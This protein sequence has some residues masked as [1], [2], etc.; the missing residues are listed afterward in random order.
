PCVG[1]PL[2]RFNAAGLPDL[3]IEL[4]EDFAQRPL[5]EQHRLVRGMDGVL[6][7]LGTTVDAAFLDAAGPSLKV[8]SNYAVGYDNIDLQ[9]AAS[10]NVVVCNGPPPMTEPTADLAWM[11]LI[12]A[13]RRAREGL[14]LAL[15][16]NWE[17]YH[18]HL[19][20]GRRLVG[21]TLLVV[22]AGRIGSAIARRSLGWDMEVLYVARSDKPELEDAPL[23]ARRVTL[24][25]GLPLAD[26]VM[27]SVGLTP[28]TRG[29]IGA[30]ELASMKST[31]VLVNVSRGPVVREEELAAALRSGSV[32]AAGIDVYEQEPAIHPELLACERAFLMPHLGSATTEDRSDLTDIA[33]DNIVAVMRGKDPPFRIDCGH[34]SA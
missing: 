28:E 21:R 13:A 29:L 30:R 22:G 14:D 1:D 20:L 10:R 2:A 17:G 31:A 9:A 19:L 12:G 8:V 32:F 24:E 5:E 16:G 15:S 25:E 33:V 7:G 4:I 3:S 26:A 23:H 18:P 27:I 11:L 6:T 34:S